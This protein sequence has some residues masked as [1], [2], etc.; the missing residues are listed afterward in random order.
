MVVFLQ[1]NAKTVSILKSLEI[2]SAPEV[3]AVFTA[4]P[5]VAQDKLQRLR[6]LIIEV[7]TELDDVTSLEESL[8]WGEP[9]YRS[10]I[11][12]TIRINWNKK[13]PNQYSMFF[14]CSTS[15][16]ETFRVVFS[17]VFRF[18]GKRAIHFDIDEGIAEDAL[19]QCIVA[20][21]RYHK[22]KTLPL[23]GI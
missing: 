22:V 8:K 2:K 10:N 12:S 21:L 23:L 1:P 16:V 18:E 15:L 6:E 14:Q 13:Y 19:R 4:F 17:E 11:G 20:G 7:A 3:Q 9:S 5:E